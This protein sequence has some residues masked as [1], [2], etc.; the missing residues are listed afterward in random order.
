MSTVAINLLLDTTPLGASL[1]NRDARMF[2]CNDELVRLF[3]TGTKEECCKRFF[4]FTP[5][6]Q[7]DGEL[8][9]TKAKRYINEAFETGKC[10]F[11]WLHALPDGKPMPGEVTFVRVEYEDD[12]AVAAYFRDMSEHNAMMRDIHR[13]DLL[14]EITNTVSGI[15]LQSDA[16]HFL[17]DLHGCMGM[18]AKALDIDHISIW[19]NATVEEELYY[20][21]VFEWTNEAK[22]PDVAIYEPESLY[23]N[24][25]LRCYSKNVPGLYSELKKGNCT[26]N[27]VR[28]LPE[29]DRK[30]LSEQGIFSLFVAPIFIQDNFWGIV[31]YRNYHD[32][33]LF[34]DS[35]QTIMH[36]GSLV[37]ANAL[38]QNE[39]KLHL[40][41]SALKLEEA[42]DE[43][44][45]ANNAKSEFLARVS[46]EIRTPLNAVLG[47]TLLLLEKDG[48][49]Q[50][51]YSNLDNI[52]S[53]G[54][55]I[56]DLVNDVLDISKIESGVLDLENFKYDTLS[57]LNDAI[58]QNILR[59][60]EKP[61]E[62]K[63]SIGEN[64]FLYLTGDELRVKQIINNLLS[65]AIKYTDSGEVELITESRR[66]DED[67]WLLIKVRDT[68]R[69]I[70][71][72]D[73]SKLYDDYLRL[74]ENANH[75]VEG[76]GLGLS[77]TKRLCDLMQGT[78]NV[79][80]E[81]GKGSI[82]TVK[83]KQAFVSD[84]KI[85]PDVV[86]NLNAI[87]YSRSKSH[88]DFRSN[89]E[90]LP[91][92][93]VLIVDDNLTNLEVARGLFMPYGMKVDCV[94]NGKKAI[95][96]ISSEPDKYD[97]I[98]LDQMMP[99]MDGVETASYIRSLGT[100]Y[101]NNIPII[102]FTANAVSGNEEMFMSKGFQ[103]F[104][105][106]PIDISKLDDIILK[107]VHNKE[108]EEQYKEN[109]DNNAAK[110]AKEAEKVAELLKDMKIEDLNIQEGAKRFG[111]DEITYLRILRTYS[112][113]TRS[114]LKK[115]DP[116]DEED[117]KNYEVI[118]H[119]IKS[120][121]KDIC[122]DELGTLAEQLENAA[123]STD[124]TYLKEKNPYFVKKA[125]AMISAIDVLLGTVDKD[126]P[127]QMKEKLDIEL[128]GE[129]L[130]ACEAF[131]ID[132]V[133]AVM[134]KINVYQYINDSGLHSWLKEKADM[135]KF[136][137]ISGKLSYLK[138]R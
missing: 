20:Y 91:Y 122:A 138:R 115:I 59:I 118:V 87:Q 93:R 111:R 83:L 105:T 110:E 57:M 79:E 128:L 112:N 28:D 89:I 130:K 96:A 81:Y 47:L 19:K 129:L 134:E 132:K 29:I 64:M 117:I 86:K 21:R 113:D 18:F 80:S 82:F 72:E 137:E 116:V 123:Q 46:H 119:G 121:S 11:T 30:F 25:N 51:I 15:L 135:M 3:N 124:I 99:G 44:E 104:L 120:S 56:L 41:S 27:L 84:E 12:Y 33:R 26:N 40:M 38:S 71:N 36:S 74:D 77:I 6:Y 101:A 54:A 97:A 49:D 126:N 136:K 58:T 4:D 55:T 70:K 35:E 16:K 32:E 109:P 68:G 88:R 60:G 2:L 75:S 65:N 85:D 102:A 9:A 34:T 108:K 43:A 31:S 95:D 24:E 125:R 76:I 69:G 94:N 37:I 63:L 107:W 53:S 45:S 42:R 131:D 10:T 1:W 98:F 8:S 61:I 133:D 67:V 7:P 114:L 62:F 13:R 92:A 39:M 103:G 100:D 52:Y 78:I 22:T 106:K 50:D 14:L 23:S 17:K 127:K 48:L 66:E 90:K 73:I 5:K